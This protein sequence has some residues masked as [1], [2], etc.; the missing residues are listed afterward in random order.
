MSYFLIN[1]RLILP[2][3]EDRNR[4]DPERK[5]GNPLKCGERTRRRFQPLWDRL[6]VWIQ[7]LSTS[8]QVRKPRWH[9]VFQL[10]SFAHKWTTDPRRTTNGHPLE[11][12]RLDG[13]L[14]SFQQNTFLLFKKWI[15]HTLLHKPRCSSS[16]QK[17]DDFWNT[18]SDFICLDQIVLKQS[19]DTNWN[20]TSSTSSA[21]TAPQ[22]RNFQAVFPIR[23]TS[24]TRLTQ[25]NDTDFKEITADGRSIF[26][27]RIVKSS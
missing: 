22:S 20:R 21:G 14:E 4:W 9:F 10:R 13:N 7:D 18:V 19:I 5:Q 16:V 17:T 6:K 25:K 11:G 15:P 3:I 12:T 8:H 2:K 23:T 26:W 1:H 27:R 24:T